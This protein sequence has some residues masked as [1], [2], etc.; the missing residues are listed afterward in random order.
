MYN[1]SRSRQ[2]QE[3]IWKRQ[4]SMGRY[5]RGQTVYFIISGMEVKE[6]EVLR[7][8]GKD[9]VLKFESWEGPGAVRLPESRIYPDRESAELVV[10]RK[11]EAYHEEERQKKAREYREKHKWAHP[12]D[13]WEG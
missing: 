4:S 2:K 8:A 1:D 3:R 12:G 9:C 6:A 11:K 5:L 7:T 10:K 13:D